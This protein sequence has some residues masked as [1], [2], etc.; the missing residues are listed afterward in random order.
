MGQENNEFL[1]EVTLRI[2]SSLKVKTALSRT[3]DYLKDF[4][5]V[6]ECFFQMLDADLSM[7]RNIAYISVD[8]DIPPTAK[9]ILQMTKEAWEW[10][11]HL[12]GPYLVHKKSQDKFTKAIAEAVGLLDNQDLL[13]PLRIEERPVGVLVL[14][15]FDHKIFT[16]Q[17][18]DLLSVIQ[19]P[20]S[21]AMSNALAHEATLRHKNLLID[22]NKFLKNELQRT[23]PKKI[24]GAECGLRHVMEMIRQV[25]PLSSNVLILGETGV[26]KEVIANAIH[27]SSGRSKKPFI[28]L[29]CGAIPDNLID[30]EL[31]GHEKGAF[32]GAIDKKRGRFERAHTGTLFLDEIGELHLA[33]Q[34]K[35]LRVIQHHE[36]ERIGS[37]ETTPVDVRVIAATHR[38]LAEMIAENKFR[39]DLWFRLNVFP[40]FIPPLRNRLEDIPELA[41]Y[42]INRKCNQMR[43]S[44]PPALSPDALSR[45]KKYH[46]PGNVRELENVIEREL[47]LHPKGPLQFIELLPQ[48]R[49]VSSGIK[50][51]RSVQALQSLDEVITAHIQNVL[52]AS[53]G[54]VSGPGGA[55]EILCVNESTLRSKMRKF[56]IHFGHRM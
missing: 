40:I 4:F 30:S 25:G 11:N 42:F 37:T 5:P 36:I 55:A 6:R 52:K 1:N 45:L 34:V 26:G 31:F 41:D 39:E 56:G 22:D 2:C 50:A 27:Y 15:A 28:K 14:R 51:S 29:N 19:T 43:I 47:I 18:M 49:G 48:C 8:K 17:H 33:A 35:L 20:F 3:F 7:V 46:W 24:I 13:L 23:L 10:L 21:I 32:T 16:K 54:K 9:P 12:N 44:L 38:N 53:K